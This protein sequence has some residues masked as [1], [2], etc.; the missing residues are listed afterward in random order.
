MTLTFERNLFHV[1][2]E[3][4]GRRNLNFIF[5]GG[6]CLRWQVQLSTHRHFV[7]LS[8]RRHWAFERRGHLRV[9]RRAHRSNAAAVAWAW[10]FICGE[11]L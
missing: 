11:L 5:P 4:F 7:Q 1:K 3:I 6:N 9:N 8:T 10:G 2:Q